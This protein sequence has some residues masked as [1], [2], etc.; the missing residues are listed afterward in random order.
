MSTVSWRQAGWEQVGWKEVVWRDSN[1]TG[2]YPGALS[3]L[4]PSKLT[5]AGV[6][7]SAKGPAPTFTDVPEVT[8]DG[9]TPGDGPSFTSV[10]VWENGGTRVLIWT[11]DI[12]SADITDDVEI[13][14]GFWATSSGLEFRDGTNTAVCATSWAADEVVTAIA[15]VF[16]D[17][18]R[19]LMRIQRGEE[20]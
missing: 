11:P 8:A 20:M 13:G 16:D 14:G 6:L 5:D 4:W 12:A 2:G 9:V 17:G 19:G 10:V 1:E 18:V 15:T 7:K 3:L